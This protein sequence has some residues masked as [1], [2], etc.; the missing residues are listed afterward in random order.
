MDGNKIL[1][2][3]QKCIVQNCFVYKCIKCRL[4]LDSFH[5]LPRKDLELRKRW[6]LYSG[7]RE[8]T[9]DLK[10][11][12]YLCNLH[13]S[14][15]CY[16]RRKRPTLKKSDF[17]T[18]TIH[19]LPPLPQNIPTPEN[20]FGYVSEHFQKKKIFFLVNFFFFTFPNLT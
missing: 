17:F 2:H 18:K 20:F 7:K 11:S 15:S 10:K 4:I 12:Y 3:Y 19:R 6:L 5:K 8:L 9:H 16:T 1:K 13:F 14:K